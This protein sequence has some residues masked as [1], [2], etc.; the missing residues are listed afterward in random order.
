MRFQIIIEGTDEEQMIDLF[1]K[2]QNEYSLF[3]NCVLSE[4]KDKDSI[5][6][7][8]DRCE[9][10]GRIECTRPKEVERLS[11][12]ELTGP[13]YLNKIFPFGG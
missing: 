2:I 10:T 11:G 7:D 12:Y 1:E 5:I 3:D 9:E 4:V 6:D 13:E 8:E